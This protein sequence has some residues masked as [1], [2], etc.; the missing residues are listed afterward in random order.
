MQIMSLSLVLNYIL[1]QNVTSKF[2]TL[3]TTSKNPRPLFMGVYCLVIG[4]SILFS[5]KCVWTR[6]YAVITCMYELFLLLHR[7][8]GTA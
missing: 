2:P 1:C 7:A 8:S 5:L 3:I 6:A 4:L